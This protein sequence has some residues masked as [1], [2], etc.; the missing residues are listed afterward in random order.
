MHNHCEVFVLYHI[1]STLPGA[2]FERRICQMTSRKLA[3]REY[4]H[5]ITLTVELD[6]S[7]PKITQKNN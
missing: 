1:P 5:A 6:S 7:C 2:E 3:K 4:H